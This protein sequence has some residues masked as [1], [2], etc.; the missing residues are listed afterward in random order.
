[1][2]R[3]NRSDDVPDRRGASSGTEVVVD[4]G[5]HLLDEPTVGRD[6]SDD[7]DGIRRIDVAKITGMTP[8]VFTLIGM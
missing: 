2:I 4:P 5:S 1:M 3:K 7:S 8:A 6:G